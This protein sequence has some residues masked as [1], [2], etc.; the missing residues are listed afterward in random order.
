LIHTIIY[1]YLSFNIRHVNDFTHPNFILK[2][3]KANP[4]RGSILLDEIR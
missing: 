1:G 2:F 4:L 3:P